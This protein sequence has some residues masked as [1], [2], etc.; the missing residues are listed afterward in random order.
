MD[1]AEIIGYLSG[2]PIYSIS[3]AGGGGGGGGGAADFGGPSA[4]GYES[5]TGGFSGVDTGFSGFSG[6]TS[7]DMTP[8]GAFAGPA[9][10]TNTGAGTGG[11]GGS[12]GSGGGPSP[13]P[14]PS[15]SRATSP[16]G[17]ID[18][19]RSSQANTAP[20]EYTPGKATDYG[21]IAQDVLSGARKGAT[22]GAVA[23][24]PGIAVGG[25]AGGIIGGVTSK[26]RGSPAS[27]SGVDYGTYDPN[28]PFGDSSQ[29]LL[30]PIEPG[31]PIDAFSGRAVGIPDAAGV[32]APSLDPA[33]AGPTGGGGSGSGEGGGSGVGGGLPD[34]P[35]LPKPPNIPLPAAPPA[36]PN[37]N[38]IIGS[39][40]PAMNETQRIL[41][42]ARR[43]G[44]QSTI[45]TGGG[46]GLPDLGPVGVPG[47]SGGSR[48]V[49]PIDTNPAQTA[50]REGTR[51]TGN[52]FQ[53]TT[54]KAFDQIEAQRE[55]QGALQVPR[56]PLEDP[57]A[58][59]GVLGEGPQGARTPDSGRV[60]PES[61]ARGDRRDTISIGTSLPSGWTF[62]KAY[63]FI[64]YD[65]VK[66]PE[67]RMWI[68]DINSGIGYADMVLG[69]G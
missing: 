52:R 67:G 28:D 61:P 55:Q 4:G 13:S 60:A 50:A 5:A 62:V 47:L 9:P 31:Q 41:E 65:V 20:G 37:P 40:G 15:S 7:P 14:A 59:S 6:A 43:F 51:P 18:R 63:K 12:S 27:I 54:I 49:A 16:P 68:R 57:V 21:T 33:T 17:P 22:V 3:G 45:L 32:S 69:I 23:G 53:N 36:H 25:I 56:Q 1:V 29:G 8:G 11:L 46:A 24:P 58:T 39:E 26:G 19:G 44:R 2:R 10:G 38:E 30:D 48:S 66:D 64:P 42:D 35:D 34:L